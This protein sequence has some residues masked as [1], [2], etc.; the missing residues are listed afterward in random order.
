[1]RPVGNLVRRLESMKINR[2]LFSGIVN[3]VPNS[4]WAGWWPA[5]VLLT[6]LYFYFR[7]IHSE[8]SG[9]LL[10]QWMSRF[11]IEESDELPNAKPGFKSM[12]WAR[13]S[14]FSVRNSELDEGNITDLDSACEVVHRTFMSNTANRPG[15]FCHCIWKVCRDISSCRGLLRCDK[16]HVEPIFEHRNLYIEP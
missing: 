9:F 11:E 16:R 3:V 8:D 1:M 4:S 10:T 13:T 14:Y 7:D 12:I 2:C 5:A 6:I 15:N